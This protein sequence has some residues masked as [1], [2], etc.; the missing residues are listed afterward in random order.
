MSDY[1]DALGKTVQIKSESFSITGELTYVDGLFMTVRLNGTD[2]NVNLDSLGPYR[3]DVVVPTFADVL[4]ALDQGTV[5]SRKD[6][7]RY[8]KVDDRWYT[9]GEGFLSEQFAFQRDSF[10][11]LP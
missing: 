4:N 8:V 5:I 1:D 10:E 7:T 2:W 11:A 3:F 9:L 6:G